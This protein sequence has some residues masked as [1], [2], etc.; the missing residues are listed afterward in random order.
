MWGTMKGDA[1]GR[2]DIVDAHD[3]RDDESALSIAMDVHL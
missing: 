2:T 3:S 1:H